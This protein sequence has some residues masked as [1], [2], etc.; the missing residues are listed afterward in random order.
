VGLKKEG[1]EGEETDEAHA[2][3]RRL[4]LAVARPLLTYLLL[5]D[6]YIVGFKPMGAGKG[7]GGRLYDD[8]QKNTRVCEAIATDFERQKGGQ[9]EDEGALLRRLTRVQGGGGGREGGVEV[10]DKEEKKMEES[11]REEGEGGEDDVVRFVEWGSNC[12]F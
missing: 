10:E 4:A 1:E 12:I 3:E 11:E 8:D 2:E 9:G 6:A 5:L 7:E